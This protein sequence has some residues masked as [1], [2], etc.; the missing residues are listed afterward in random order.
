[1]CVLIDRISI[2]IGVRV[3]SA[4]GVRWG[5]A[6]RICVASIVVLTGIVA[7]FSKLRIPI[8]LLTVE[9]GVGRISIIT[10]MDW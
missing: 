2:R 3:S 8:L 1:M 4:I 7:P 6:A 10:L 5:R 9:N